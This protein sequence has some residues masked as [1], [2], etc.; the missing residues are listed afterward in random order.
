MENKLKINDNTVVHCP[1]E[2]LANKVLVIADKLGYRWQN[3]ISFYKNEGCTIISAEDFLKLHKEK[4][5]L[6]YIRGVEDRGDE[7]IKMLEEKGG[8]NEL[9]LDGNADMVYYIKK[10]DNLIDLVGYK[11]DL[12][13]VVTI[14]GTELFLP[15]KLKE[16]QFKPFD[17]VLVRDYKTDK[18]QCNLYSHRIVDKAAHFCIDGYWN[19]CIPYEGNKHLLGTTNNPE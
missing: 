18:W 16:Y 11:D 7:V 4:P 1:T 6:Y 13:I 3:D 9:Y 14:F 2:E 10:R 19:F 15:K 12:G 5:T 17:K 8:V